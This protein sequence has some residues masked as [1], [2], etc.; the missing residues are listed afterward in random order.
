MAVIGNI[1]DL[2]LVDL[3]QIVQLGRRTC[4]LTVDDEYGVW[5]RT[6]FE[7][8]FVVY[9]DSNKRYAPLGEDLVHAGVIRRDQLQAALAEYAGLGGDRPRFGTFLLHRGTISRET[10]VEF[11]QRKIKIKLFDMFLIEEGTFTYELT[12]YRLDEDITVSISVTELV[13]ESTKR[14]DDYKRLQRRIPSVDLIVRK[15]TR[16]LA[17]LLRGDYEFT[18]LEQEIL[19]LAEK[20]L[21]IRE[22][23]EELNIDDQLEVL[24]IVN[25]FLNLGLV[26][27]GIPELV[28]E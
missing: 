17:E 2:T 8:G 19:L 18:E 22:M 1:R 24:K 21:T 26:H 20:G 28:A 16:P 7:E 27:L 6:Y 13:M 4:V 5:Y 23:A 10:L 25:G 11:I 9:A 14:V 12:P 15:E 3:F